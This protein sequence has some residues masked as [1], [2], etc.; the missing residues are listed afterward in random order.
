M[1]GL[2]DRLKQMW[3]IRSFCSGTIKGDGLLGNS[4]PLG[5]SLAVICQIELTV[6]YL[7]G[8]FR[9]RRLLTTL[10][11]DLQPHGIPSGPLSHGLIVQLAVTQI[12]LGDGRF[13][14]VKRVRIGEEGNDG[15]QNS[16]CS[17]RRAPF[18][19]EYVQAHFTRMVD[20]AVVNFGPETHCRRTERVFSWKPDVEKEAS[21]LV[22][23]SVRSPDACLPC[24]KTI[25][26]W[27]HNAIRW[28]I[29]DDIQKLPLQPLRSS[30]EYRSWSRSTLHSNWPSFLE[31]T[32][33]LSANP[34]HLRCHGYNIVAW[35]A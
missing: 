7:F 17:Q 11:L 35:D 23:R 15:R 22:W 30:H 27:S 5:P 19:F 6:D 31:L 10:G 18:V 20:V 32:H 16:R 33:R 26:L 34:L 29:S 9:L 13:Q 21:P 12:L 1:R 4:S 14:R 25:A 8:L 3:Q 24:V 28:W 2:R